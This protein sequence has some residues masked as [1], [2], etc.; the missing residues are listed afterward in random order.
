MHYK[1]TYT[2]E[3]SLFS[4]MTVTDIG[5]S[6]QTMDRLYSQKEIEMPGSNSLES[7]Q[8]VEVAQ[9]NKKERK[10]ETAGTFRNIADVYIIEGDIIAVSINCR[11]MI[12]SLKRS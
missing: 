3:H 2:N 9:L 10:K 5:Q 12:K 7:N 11:G 4:E 6:D 1:E 8:L